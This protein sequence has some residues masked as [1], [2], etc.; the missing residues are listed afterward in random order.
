VLTRYTTTNEA[1]DGRR[2]HHRVILFDGQ[3]YVA[4]ETFVE[5]LEALGAARRSVAL[6]GRE[7]WQV[8]SPRL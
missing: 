1:L 7:V 4:S 5:A 3:P 2:G 8:D 6:G